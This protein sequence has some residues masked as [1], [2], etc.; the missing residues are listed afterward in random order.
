[1]RAAVSLLSLAVALAPVSARSATVFALL[2]T[3]ELFASTDQGTSWTVRAAL[4]VRDAVALVAGATTS[5]LYLASRSGSIHRSEDAGLGWTAVGTVAAPDVVDLLVRADR[6]V[7]VLTATGGVHRSTDEGAGFTPLASLA[8]ADFTSL[9]QTLP[10]QALHALT[11]SGDLFTSTDGGSSWSPS[12]AIT[13]SDA[14]ALRG[15]GSALHAITG[16]G[17]SY[18]S[19]DAGATWSAIG[20]LSQVGARALARDGAALLVALGTGEVARSPDGASWT[21]QGTIDQLTVTALGVDTPA[22]A[23]VGPA[24]GPGT[25]AMSAP[26]PNPARGEA[27]FTVAFRLPA[28]DGIALHLHDLAGRRVASRAWERFPAGDHALLWAPRPRATGLYLLRLV[29]ASGREAQAK[30]VVTR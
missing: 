30:V 20:T 4:P 21:W 6:S 22:T 18:R 5:R 16:A 17:D 8:G 13:V 10:D 29:T 26:R 19:V 15:V 7:L 11:R 28:A 27:G 3:G 23:G 14:V 2:D 12:G 25:V 1:M 24:A 9:T